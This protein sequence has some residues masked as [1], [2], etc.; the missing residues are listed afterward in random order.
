MSNHV[1]ELY[2]VPEKITIADILQQV[3]G[4]FSRKFNKKFYRSG[5]FWKNKPYYR[6]IE[7]EDYALTTMNYFHWNPVRANIV[8]KPEFWPFSGYRFH[9]IGER[10]GLLGKLLSPL[11]GT[12]LV[13]RNPNTDSTVEKILKSPRRR[14]IG[15]RAFRLHM[16]KTY[17]K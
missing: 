9:T 12:T 7:N 3:K 4:G 11:P 10:K 5:H 15:S 17:G 13:W 8:S 1:H 16:K 14:F 6:I 2:R